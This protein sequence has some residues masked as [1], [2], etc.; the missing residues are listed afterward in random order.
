MDCI[1]LFKK[2]AAAMQT[3]PRLLALTTAQKACDEDQ[4]LQEL[5]GQFNLLRIDLNEEIGKSERD[6]QKIAELNEKVGKV[7]QE[8]METSGMVA[9]NEAKTAVEGMINHINA[10]VNTAVEGGDPMLVEEPSASCTGS[11]SAAPAA[12]NRAF[13]R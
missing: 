10:I 5:I 3:D 4:V 1:E 13:F 7:Y 11:C 12:T 9:Y 6:N 8:I 2:A